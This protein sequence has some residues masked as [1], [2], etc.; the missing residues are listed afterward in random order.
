MERY[1]VTPK[2]FG[3]ILAGDPLEVDKKGAK[4]LG[5]DWRKVKHIRWAN[6]LKGNYH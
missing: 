5:K 2:K 3:L 1:G 4:I 6:E